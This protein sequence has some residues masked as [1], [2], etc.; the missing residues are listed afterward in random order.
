MY[1]AGNVIQDP[2][3]D[4][5]PAPAP[6]PSLINQVAQ[7][8]LDCVCV[9]RVGSDGYKAGKDSSGPLRRNWRGNSGGLREC[10]QETPG[11]IGGKND[12]A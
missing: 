6:G 12:V 11:V 7:M 8:M 2:N 9:W 4:L 10:F 5:H 3:P 1:M